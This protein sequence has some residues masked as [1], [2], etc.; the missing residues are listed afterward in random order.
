M[1]DNRKLLDLVSVGPATVRDLAKMGITRVDQ[2]R[3]QDAVEMCLRLHKITQERVDP[4]VEDVFRAAIEQARDPEL[5][6]EKC[7]WFYWSKIRK[8]RD[9]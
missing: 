8:Q 1:K 2:L 5:S 4:C 7:Q 3:D 6:Q 9:F